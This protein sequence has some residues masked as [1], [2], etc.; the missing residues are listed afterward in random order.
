MKTFSKVKK[1]PTCV[2]SKSGICGPK[3]GFA[4]VGKALTSSIFFSSQNYQFHV[5]EQNA[6]TKPFDYTGPVN[7][8]ILFCTEKNTTQEHKL[9]L[10]F[11]NSIFAR[12]GAVYLRSSK[13]ILS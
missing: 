5:T 9:P 8:H 10:H 3:G 7:E 11:P 6:G 4:T 13:V 1:S 2:Q 12:V